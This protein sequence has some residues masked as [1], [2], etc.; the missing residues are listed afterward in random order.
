MYTAFVSS[1]LFPLHERL[2][3][4]DS[5]ARR[6]ELE[7]TQWLGHDELEQL[8]IERMRAFLIRIGTEVP[9][10]RQRFAAA[11]FDPAGFASLSDLQALPL[12]TKADIR[13][14]EQALKNPGE[15][16]LLRYNTGGSSGEP[17]CSTWAWTGSATMWLPSGG[18]PGG[19]ASTSGIRRW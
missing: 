19:G 12:L 16:R 11:G 6:R 9:F 5:V 15:Q 3:H 8:R 18:P 17:W 13:A 2:K 10:Y 7:R 1:V 14:N 4:H